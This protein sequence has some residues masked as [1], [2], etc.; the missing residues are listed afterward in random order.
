MAF[1]IILLA[2]RLVSIAW[3]RTD[4]VMLFK[5]E[6]AQSKTSIASFRIWTYV[7]DSIHDD[8]DCYAKLRMC[9]YDSLSL[10]HYF[11]TYIYIYIYIFVFVCVCVLKYMCECCQVE[12]CT[13]PCIQKKSWFGTL[14]QITG[15]GSVH[16]LQI[17]SIA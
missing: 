8:A 10:S 11:T 2:H 14:L 9:L 5:R 16:Q 7:T 4:G 12:K 1:I 17:S 15:E 6:L 13:F 3:A